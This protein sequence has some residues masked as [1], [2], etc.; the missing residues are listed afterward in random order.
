MD[1]CVS[2][3]RWH[4]HPR[5]RKEWGQ[6]GKSNRQR[7]THT[8]KIQYIAGTLTGKAQWHCA[9]LVS[10]QNLAA[11]GQS[12]VSN[13]MGRWQNVPKQLEGKQL[14]DQPLISIIAPHI[15]VKAINR[16]N[17]S[18]QPEK[19]N[20]NMLF[21]KKTN[22]NTLSN[23]QT[24]RNT[25]HHWNKCVKSHTTFVPLWTHSHVGNHVS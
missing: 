24:Y 20:H 4:W 5:T 15:P 23:K 16:K 21:W 3:L 2:T 8:D 13:C 10:S 18:D 17:K 19:A 6:S 25:E 1:L 9:H 14:L 22:N 11:G 7:Q 12:S